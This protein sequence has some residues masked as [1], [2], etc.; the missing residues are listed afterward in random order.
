MEEQLRSFLEECKVGK[1]EPFTHTT[2]GTGSLEH[3]FP[4]GSYY[5]DKDYLDVF[6][7]LYS[8]A[9]SKKYV[10]TVTERPGPYGPLRVDFDFKTSLDQGTNRQYTFDILKKI[11]AFYQEEIRNII[12]PTDFEEKM[13]WCVILEKPNPRVE[14][15]NI[16]D[17]F[18]IHFPYFICDGWI[19]DEYLR[20]KVT[21]KMIEEKIWNNA[22]F[23]TPIS[24]IIDKNMA[25]K[26]WMM[27]GSM[28]YKNSKSKAYLY[29][30]WSKIPEEKHF[31]HAFDSNQ[32]EIHLHILFEDEMVGRNKSVKYYLP[33]FFSIRG[34]QTYTSLTDEMIK[35]I[36][37]KSST[38][39]RKNHQVIAKKRNIEDVME[40]IKTIKDGELMSMIS[41]DRAENYEEWMDI[42]WT[43]F[44]ISQGNEECLEMWIDF[45]RRSSK[46]VESEC[47]E[48]W[49]NMESKG[50]TIAS[51]LAMAKADSPNEYKAWK[52]T[53]IRFHLWASL[54][55]PKPTEYDVAMVVTKMFG[56]KFICSNAKRNEWY[57]FE[58]H[59]WREMD[60]GIQLRKLFV[61]KV[62][63]EYLNLQSEINKELNDIEYKLGLSDKDSTNGMELAIEYK[64]I[65]SKKKRCSAVITE[66]KTSSFHRKL[67]E[68]CQIEMHDP[69]FHKKRNENRYILGCE[70]GVIDL[71]TLVFRDGR[72]D[73]YITFSTGRNYNV[74]NKEDEEVKDLDDMLLKIYPNPNLRQ[75]FIDFFSFAMKGGNSGKDW[76]IATG[77]SDGGK[78]QTFNLIELV[79]GSGNCGYAGKFTRENFVQATG[80]NS[81]SGPRPD[82]ARIRGK[83]L[84][85]G[86]EI[87]KD[88]KI[89]IG[90]IKEITGND[91]IWARGMYEKDAEEIRPQFTLYTQLNVAPDIPGDDE[92]FWSRVRKL[93]HESKFVI[94]DKLKQFPVPE[95]FKEQLEM[96]RFN[97]DPDFGETLPDKADVLLWKLFE[98]YKELTRSKSKILRPKEVLMSTEI[99]RSNNDIYLRF[100]GDRIEKEEDLE[101][102]KVVF[103]KQPEMCSEFNEWYKEEYPSYSKDKIG[104]TTIRKEINKKLGVIYDPSKDIYG[105]GKQNRW[106]GYKFLQ[107]DEEDEE[108]LE[109]LL[110]RDN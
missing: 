106:W 29:N 16:K 51:L 98:R 22:K 17:G 80:R 21:S 74:Y 58:D 99:Y 92:A 93:D 70:N 84:M 89:N 50:K 72:P 9:V 90:F 65:T 15:G 18:H 96:K 34:F 61:K 69:L 66:L 62:I 87:T 33:R 104:K 14:E 110:G 91:S 47:E 95:T 35:K 27:Y 45:S 88:E 24:E 97:A 41:D 30:R 60:G 67:I 10:T 13:L 37:S 3:G 79:F 1:G 2:K 31:G 44:N 78:S 49:E 73:D 23:T 54:L 86:Q 39:K 8:N 4:S 102:A 108:T 43:L 46:F 55:E 25:R 56:D 85:G 48:V 36:N 28:N 63:V 64:K 7:T 57:Y 42:G 5:I 107:K 40:D 82:L 105:F 83:R 59:R 26:P 68:M 76:L 53:N 52:N 20:N 12:I 103:I 109:D 94:P 75:Y 19:Q 11:V 71:E 77:Q 81:S 100:I 6:Y 38:N 32:N 101:R